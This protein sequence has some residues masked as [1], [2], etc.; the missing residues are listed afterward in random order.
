MTS[1]FLSK[2]LVT[3]ITNV[4]G[5]TLDLEAC[6]LK[7]YDRGVMVELFRDLE[8]RTLVDRLPDSNRPASDET[9]IVTPTG[10]L[11]LFAEMAPEPVAVAEGEAPAEPMPYGLVVSEE[12][13]ARLVETLQHASLIAFDT[14]TTATDAPAGRP[15]GHLA[16]LGRGAVG[17]HSRR[18]SC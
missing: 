8:F 14:E 16:G 13:L 15:G 3:I 11:A 9:A 1:A 12:G 2:R 18:P 6:R 10:Q 7:D 17:L 5:I 4:P